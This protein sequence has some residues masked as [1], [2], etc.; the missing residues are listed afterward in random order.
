MQSKSSTLLLVYW[1]VVSVASKKVSVAFAFQSPHHQHQHQHHH[2][3]FPFALHSLRSPQ[4]SWD[5]SNNRNDSFDL[6]AARQ[7]LESL[8]GTGM[9][10][11][12]Q[13]R[14]A[15][16]TSSMDTA[17]SNTKQQQK[18]QQQQ[19][20]QRQKIHKLP[21]QLPLP[22]PPL[23]SIDRERKQ[24]EIELLKQLKDSDEAQQDLWNLWFHERGPKAAQLLLQAEELVQTGDW[25]RAQVSLQTII[26]EYGLY[27]V[28]PVHR[29]ATLYYHMGKLAKA[30][31]LC[32]TV[33]AVKPWHFGALS[34]IVVVY[35]EMH[36][37]AQ[38]RHDAA[39]RLPT[40][41]P[42]GPN[43][44]R[45]QWVE[46]AVQQAETALQAAEER[47]RADFGEKDEHDVNV[48]NNFNHNY[49]SNGNSINNENDAWQ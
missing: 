47:L 32:R 4:D 2:D 34:G 16:S 15:S 17:L 10:T 39:R 1:I 35:A 30:E 23:T 7:K 36:A 46:Q 33:L 44:R 29:L 18:Q 45:Q 38:A 48:I 20:Q 28:E 3:G 5:H 24:A 6:E 41:A 21:I 40:L 12:Q 27:W 14:S 8:V 26:A 22:V 49:Y 43:R 19:Q 31:Q 13:Q 42:Q 25:V 11:Q 9:D 37:A